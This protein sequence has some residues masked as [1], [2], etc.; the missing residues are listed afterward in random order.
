MLFMHL[1]FTFVKILSDQKS[2]GH[3]IPLNI[4]GLKTRVRRM[5]SIVGRSSQVLKSL[6]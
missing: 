1:E 6:K 4:E 3:N 2:R 5:N